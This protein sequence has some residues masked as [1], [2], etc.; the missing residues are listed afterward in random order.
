MMGGTE[1]GHVILICVGSYL[2]VRGQV[3][4]GGDLNGLSRMLSVCYK[5][6]QQLVC[7]TNMSHLSGR[8]QTS[9]LCTGDGLSRGTSIKS[10]GKWLHLLTVA[11]CQTAVTL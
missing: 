11:S 4:G 1:R 10:G 9:D 8:C 2:F 7:Q 6:I 5:T 3:G